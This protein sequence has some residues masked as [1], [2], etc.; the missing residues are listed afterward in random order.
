M[1]NIFCENCRFYGNDPKFRYPQYKNT[2][3]DRTTFCKCPKNIN[4]NANPHSPAR[5]ISTPSIINRNNDCG[6]FISKSKCETYVWSHR[7]CGNYEGGGP[8]TFS[9]DPVNGAKGFYI[10]N[11][12]LI[13]IV[14]E[15]AGVSDDVKEKI[16]NIEND[17]QG[18]NSDID[19][20][21]NQIDINNNKIATII[22]NNSDIEERLIEAEKDIGVLKN[23]NIL[24]GGDSR[25]EI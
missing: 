17:L 21:N 14:Q 5:F 6:W 25:R 23:E 3:T 20:I 16:E 11:K 24:D 9:V 12:T 18:I 4:P 1:G 10:G 8:G 19:V 7:R 2:G 15:A 13:D 22:K